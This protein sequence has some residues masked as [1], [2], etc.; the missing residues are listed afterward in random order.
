MKLTFTRLDERRYE[1]LVT[2]DDGVSFHVKGI[3]HMFA[4]PHDLAH[5]AIEEALH[6]RRGFW[7]SVAE[8]AVFP[9]MT[10]V[11]GRR[12]PR[13]ASRSAEVL[14]ANRG[15]IGESELLV[16]IFNGAIEQGCREDS[17]VL[18]QRLNEYWYPVA[19]RQCGIT[20][21]AI[22]DVF[23][24]WRRMWRA[25]HSLPIG[26]TLDL[27]WCAATHANRSRGAGRR[28]RERRSA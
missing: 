6:L 17:A 1:T 19:D 24:S 25:W 15:H 20:A 28:R 18:R 2:R 8:G 16:S 11:A 12:K 23:A 14:K 4:I 7:G 26:G 21:A 5:F 27:V 13:A 10:H 22:S 9:S 3:G